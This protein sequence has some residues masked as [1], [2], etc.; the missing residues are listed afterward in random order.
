MGQWTGITR[1]GQWNGITQMGPW[2]GSTRY[3]PMD[4]YHS[5]GPMFWFQ[6]VQSSK[7]L[8]CK[9]NVLDVTGVESLDDAV[10]E[11]EIMG[12]KG[13]WNWAFCN[14]WTLNDH[15]NISHFD[16]ASRF[17]SLPTIP[18]VKIPGYGS[19]KP[20]LPLMYNSK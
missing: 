8:P 9:P 1:M 2:T 4:W 7:C 3:G 13:R 10:G 15:K 16:V 18:L 12:N 5:D 17:S 19:G 20:L 14:L 6:H 11:C